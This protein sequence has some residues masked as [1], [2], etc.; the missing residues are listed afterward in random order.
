MIHDDGH[1]VQ[2]EVI[3]LGHHT[4]SEAVRDVVA[5]QKSGENNQDVEG[6]ERED[7]RVPNLSMHLSK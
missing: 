1:A 5:T 3:R 7:D 2:T 6:N 4:L